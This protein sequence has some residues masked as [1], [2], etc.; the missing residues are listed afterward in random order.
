MCGGGGK[1]PPMPEPQAPPAPTPVRDEAI[2]AR[3]DRQLAARRAASGAT[4]QS[5]MLSGTGGA[6]DY[7]PITS[8]VLG[9]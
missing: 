2:A 4:A 5:T 1:A 9:G 7:A 6:G 8:P 3:S